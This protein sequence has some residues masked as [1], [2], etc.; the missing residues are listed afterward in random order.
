FL[1]VELFGSRE[2]FHRHHAR[3]DFARSDDCVIVARCA[4]VVYDRNVVAG[5]GGAAVAEQSDLGV[6]RCSQTALA[7]KLFVLNKNSNY[8]SYLMARRKNDSTGRGYASGRRPQASTT[9]GMH[10]TVPGVRA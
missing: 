3:G 6:A 9:R 7:R 4:G 8:G 10:P 5:D 1:F 2:I